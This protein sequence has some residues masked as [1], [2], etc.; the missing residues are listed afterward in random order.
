MKTNNLAENFLLL[1]FFWTSLLLLRVLARVFG[2]ILCC[3]RSVS[4]RKHSFIFIRNGV[5]ERQKVDWWQDRIRSCDRDDVG[6]HTQNVE[7]FEWACGEKA[8]NHGGTF[9]GMCL[10]IR[11]N[12]FQMGI[13]SLIKSV[14]ESVVCF[15]WIILFFYSSRPIM[16]MK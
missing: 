5:G 12:S 6:S 3:F 16:S 14:V 15:I 4:Q 9:A 10:D 13:L 11:C 7:V 2:S 1:F 8:L